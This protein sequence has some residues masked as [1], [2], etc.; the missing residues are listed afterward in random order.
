MTNYKN[1]PALRF[2]EFEGEWEKYK[3]IDL[4]KINAGGDIKKPNVSRKKTDEFCYPIGCDLNIM[5]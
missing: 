4:F 2:K 1:I 3:A 5:Y